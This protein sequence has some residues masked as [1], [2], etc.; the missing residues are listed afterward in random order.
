MRSGKGGPD[1]QKWGDGI[2]VVLPVFTSGGTHVNVSGAVV[3]KGAPNR[4]EAVKLL[5]YLV[6]DEGQG[7]YAKANFEYPVKVGAPIDPQLTALGPLTIDTVPLAEIARNRKAA[8]P[9]GGYGRLRQ[10]KPRPMRVAAELAGSEAALGTDVVPRPASR[11]RAG[12]LAWAAGALALAALILSPVVS[13]SLTAAGGSSEVWPHLLAHVLPQATLTTAVLLGGVGLLV[14]MLGVGSAWL[15]SAYEFR[16]RRLLEIGLL[17]PLAVPTYIVAFA[18]L[19]LLHP[20]GP[21]QTALRDALGVARPKDLLLPEIRSLPGCILL[22]GF[23]L[24]PYVYLPTRAL[25]LMQ[26]GTLIEAARILGRSP[27]AVFFHVALAAGA[28]RHRPR[29]QPRPDGDAQRYR[30]RRISR[31]KDAYGSGLRHLDQPLRSA[32]RS[33]DRPGHAGDG[34]PAAGGRTLG[35]A[36]ARLFRHGTA[37]ARHVPPSPVRRVGPSRLVSRHV[38]PSPSVS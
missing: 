24:Y 7:L 32:R 4:D 22:L 28:P 35:P 27:M 6:S 38:F 15:V 18:Y 9:A 8:R 29:H 20:I 14:V 13:L 1:Q 25:F 33:A 37:P 17:L 16:G 19:D 30:R 34:A 3:A 26:A 5:E 36:R 10:L 31:R 12:P 2:K 21:V 11:L 23:V